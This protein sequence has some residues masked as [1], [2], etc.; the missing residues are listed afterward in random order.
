V[1]RALALIGIAGLVALLWSVASW[2]WLG[3]AVPDTMVI[4]LSEGGRPDLRQRLYYFW[5][6]TCSR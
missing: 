2:F 1:R 3:S 5:S 4:K 6:A